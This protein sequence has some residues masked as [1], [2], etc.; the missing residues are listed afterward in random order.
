METNSA[1]IATSSQGEPYISICHFIHH[2]YIFQELLNIAQPFFLILLMEFFK[3][4]STMPVW[5]AWLLAVSTVLV[6]F[7]SSIL[8]NQVSIMFVAGYN[9]LSLDLLSNFNPGP[10]NASCLHWSCFS[11]SKYDGI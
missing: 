8:F 10:T 3:P 11:K 6:A 1:R 9:S 5:L 7:V 4:C 2:I